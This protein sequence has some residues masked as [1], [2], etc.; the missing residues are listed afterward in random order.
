MITANELLI[1][2]DEAYQLPDWA[3]NLPNSRASIPL[4]MES[5]LVKDFNGYLV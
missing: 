4:R 3:V 5:K 1:L 2:L